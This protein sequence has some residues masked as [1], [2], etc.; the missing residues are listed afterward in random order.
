MNKNDGMGL[1]VKPDG[2]IDWSFIFNSD[3]TDYCL[4]ILLAEGILSGS[5]LGNYTI[6]GGKAVEKLFCNKELYFTNPEYALSFK[7]YLL[8]IINE[9]NIARVTLPN[10]NFFH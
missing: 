6:V 2:V 3:K 7:K 5:P 8:E 9:S 1:F 10:K 4:N